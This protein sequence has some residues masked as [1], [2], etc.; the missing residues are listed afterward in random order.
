MVVLGATC[1]IFYAIKGMNDL[2]DKSQRLKNR[3]NAYN[4]V[5]NTQMAVL[6]DIKR[7]NPAEQLHAVMQSGSTAAAAEAAATAEATAVAAVAAVAIP[8][9]LLEASS[10]S[11][12]RAAAAAADNRVPQP[13]SAQEQQQQ[14]L[15]SDGQLWQKAYTACSRLESFWTG[16]LDE[17]ETDELP[18]KFGK[19]DTKGSI[20]FTLIDHDGDNKMLWLRR[21]EDFRTLVEPFAVILWNNPRAPAREQASAP[22]NTSPSPTLEQAD[23]PS[24]SRKSYFSRRPRIYIRL[25]Q[26]SKAWI[27]AT[28]VA[29][30]KLVPYELSNSPQ[31]Q[32]ADLKAQFTAEAGAPGQQ[33]ARPGAC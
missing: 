28:A 30:E 23:A 6:R 18:E 21:A 7:A 9:E 4:N 8:P 25:E 10:P 33:P 17:I 16:F 20:E 13:V 14:Q 11:D 31:E 1:W 12:Q 19:N 27:K 26:I 22:S 29:P 2:V 5:M 24:G 32:P 15:Q 3:A